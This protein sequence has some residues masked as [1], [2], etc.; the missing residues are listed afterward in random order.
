MGWNFLVFLDTRFGRFTGIGAGLKQY[1]YITTVVNG[2]FVGDC[3][4]IPYNLTLICVDDGVIG[5]IY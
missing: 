1:Y 4:S 3:Q 5:R 2:R